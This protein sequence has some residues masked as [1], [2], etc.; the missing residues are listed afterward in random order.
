MSGFIQN[1]N[2]YNINKIKYYD[3]LI[4][5]YV[6]FHYLNDIKTVTPTAKFHKRAKLIFA[7]PKSK[8]RN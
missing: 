2:H 3:E 5:I 1:V 4:L 7:D 6:N 8:K